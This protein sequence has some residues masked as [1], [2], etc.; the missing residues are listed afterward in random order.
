MMT[1]KENHI[2]S[3][4]AQE[5]LNSIKEMEHAGLKRVLRTPIWAVAILA[6]AIGTQIALVGAGI[7]TYNTLLILL[8]CF[9]PAVI[10]YQN[11]LADVTE[12]VILSTRTIIVSIIC[13]IPTYFLL[14]ITA[15][16]LKGT[17]GFGWAPFAIG[18][19][20]AIGFFGI[21]AVA[22][23]SYLSRIRKNKS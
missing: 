23:S 10:A 8:I 9:M 15:Q 14:I 18:T 4:E 13:I 16:Y 20:V 22:R 2:G 7:R 11:S 5:A 19:L 17:F 21:V 6:L 3:K 1:N 12:R